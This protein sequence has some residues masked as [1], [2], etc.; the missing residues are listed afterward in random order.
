MQ[1]Y[2]QSFYETFNIGT[3]NDFSVLEVITTFEEENSVKLN[4]L[5]GKKREGDAAAT[6]ADVTKAN[7]VLNW[8]AE[9]G[10]KEIVKDAWRWEKAIST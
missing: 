7:T 1:Q 8:K 4:Y 6:F 2:L 10:L 3:G 9:K 5:I